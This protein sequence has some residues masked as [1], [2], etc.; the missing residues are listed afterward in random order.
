MLARSTRRMT[1]DQFLKLYEGTEGKYELVNGQVYAMAGGSE[2]HADVC[3]NIASA[4]RQKLRGTGCRPFNS[5]M[6]LTLSDETLRYPDIAV[7][8]DKRDLERN[9][10]EVRAFRF[11]KVI[12]EVLSPSTADE[13]RSE[14]LLAY[15]AIDS[16]A[17][18]VFVDPLDQT[19]E[20]HDR[21]TP[22]EWRHLILPP[23]SGL[24]LRDPAIELSF[25]EIF[26][27]D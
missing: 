25:E 3:L 18:I 14:K 7:Y 17:A 20:L 10:R 4:L 9:L 6:G 1:V 21:V 16:V 12:V 23:E 5:D 15:K 11:P 13:D 24:M 22:N 19:L 2:K 8:C 27:V 26:A